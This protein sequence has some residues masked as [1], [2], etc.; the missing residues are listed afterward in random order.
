MFR[1]PPT[2][3]EAEIFC[4]VICYALGVATIP[5]IRGALKVLRVVGILALL[6]LVLVGIYQ[7][8]SLLG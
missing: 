2:F 8:I 7:T 1:F 6:G 4:F 3:S 5:V